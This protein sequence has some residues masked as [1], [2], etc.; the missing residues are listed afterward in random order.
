MNWALNMRCVIWIVS[1]PQGD[2]ELV[3]FVVIKKRKF[4]WQ[5]RFVNLFDSHVK[6][7]YYWCP[8][9]DCRLCTYEKEERRR[10]D[11]KSNNS[12]TSKLIMQSVDCNKLKI[13]F[14]I[15]PRKK[16]RRHKE[17]QKKKRKAND[18]K[19]FSSYFF[20]FFSYSNPIG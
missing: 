2:F 8:Q 1:C 4:S 3:D 16:K 11:D 13:S 9:R 5:R 20:I 7:N 12:I 18:S 19:Y 6:R 17:K 15:L 14:L 10:G